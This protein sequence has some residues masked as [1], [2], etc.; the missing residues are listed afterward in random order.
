MKN[1]L[2]SSLSLI[3][4]ICIFFLLGLLLICFNIC[5]SALLF[6][7]PAGKQ[8]LSEI[9]REVERKYIGDSAEGK[10]TMQIVTRHYTR[11]MSM[12]YWSKGKNQFLI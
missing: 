5:P 9:I 8:N 4:I 1:L 7:A 3:S 11:K 2:Y 6:A 12:N 10:M